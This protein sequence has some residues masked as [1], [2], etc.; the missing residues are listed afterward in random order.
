MNEL[1]VPDRECGPCT[2]CCTVHVI[3]DPELRKPPGVTCP[4]CRS[5]SGCAIYDARPRTCRG[6]FCAWRQLAQ[7][8]ESWRPDLSN[9]YFELKSDPP[10][11]YRHVLPQAP[12]GLR[13]MLLGDLDT[14][15]L[16]KLALTVA[17]LVENQVPVILALAAP[18]HH[19]GGSLLLN[20]LLKPFAA[21]CGAAYMEAFAKALHTCM[22]LPPQKIAV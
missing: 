3:I 17:A 4:H 11:H 20:P 2:V 12:F 7:L 22:N 18:E 13:I 6:H 14:A 19:L 10:E 16:G 9:V 1:L 8:D 15:R 21:E 5:G